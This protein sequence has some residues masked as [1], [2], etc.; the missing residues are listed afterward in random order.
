M[1][2]NIL[3]YYGFTK[4]LSEME[5]FVDENVYYAIYVAASGDPDGCLTGIAVYERLEAE[6]VDYTSDEELMKF[7]KKLGAHMEFGVKSYQNN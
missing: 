2:K 3:T 6:P 5:W 1:K 7:G 4:I